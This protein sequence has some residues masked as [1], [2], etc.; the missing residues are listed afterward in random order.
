MRFNLEKEEIPEF[1]NRENLYNELPCGFLSFTPE[2]TLLAVNRT[3]ADWLGHT[4]EELIALGLK[5]MLSK[6]SLLY[7][8]LFLEPLLQVQD[9]TEEITLKMTGPTGT[10]DVLFSG[11]SYKDS[12]QKTTLI[13]AIV[14]KIIN[15]KKY[16]AELLSEKRNAELQQS[17]LKFLVNLVPIQIWTADPKGTVLTF[18]MQ[19]KNYFGDITLA[20]STGFLGILEE[21]RQMALEAWN[22]SL[23]SGKRFER[24][25]RLL[26]VSGIP[27]WFLIRAEPYYNAEA[28]EMWFCCSI[29]INKKKLLQLANQTELKSHLSHA[30]DNL[31]DKVARLSLIAME[32]SHMVRKPLANI[33]GLV[34]LIQDNPDQD[35]ISMSLKM[36]L[37]SAQ[38]LDSMLRKVS[39]NS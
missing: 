35:E 39:N 3:L 36:L 29:N 27:E 23:A 16:E 38:E 12:Q 20:D 1:L 13:N 9:S 15:R 8:N 11:K 19:V 30:Y 26:G 6:A 32:Q 4:P 14:L 24:E 22:S 2:G 5:A 33:L 17:Q 7:F 21:D 18:N 28:I 34:D 10:I 25:V 31:D 37:Q